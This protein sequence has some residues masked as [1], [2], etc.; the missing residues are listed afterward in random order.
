V[1]ANYVLASRYASTLD[2]LRQDRTLVRSTQGVPQALKLTAIYDLPF[3]R[4]RRYGSNVNAWVD[5]VIGGWALNLAGRV[6][7]GTIVNFGNVRLVGMSEDEFQKAFKVR[8][9]PCEPE[10][11]L[12]AAAG[13]HRQHDHGVQRQRHVGDGLWRAGSARP[14]VPCAGKRTRLHPAGPGRLC[15]ARSVRDRP[16][17]SRDSISTP[18]SGSYCLAERASSSQWTC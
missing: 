11:R 15:A 17:V 1:D 18:E 16:G 10:Q 7:S 5:G 6:Q 4:G 9:D 2:T 8:I 13:N 14:P 12:D 3:G